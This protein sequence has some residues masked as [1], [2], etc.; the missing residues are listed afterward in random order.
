[1]LLIKNLG[2][3]KSSRKVAPS[4]RFW[5]LPLFICLILGGCR[6]NSPITDPPEV[7]ATRV[8]PPT[9][10]KTSRQTD[11]PAPIK[12]PIRDALPNSNSSSLPIPSLW[13]GLAKVRVAGQEVSVPIVLTFKTPKH[14][15]QN[16]FFFG[17][18]VGDRGDQAGA[19]NLISS[20][21]AVVAVGNGVLGLQFLTIKPTSKGFQAVLTKTEKELAL[22]MNT[23]SG[24]NVTA[25]KGDIMSDIQAGVSGSNDLYIFN[26]GAIINVEFHEG[27]LV[28]TIKGNGFSAV[29]GTSDI[30]YEAIF[31]VIR[32]Q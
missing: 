30:P 13:R 2:M 23:F 32:D 17:L 24:I 20:T 10:Q 25:Q 6:S 22:A 14:G 9:P 19:A 11:S 12:A 3:V 21:N 27:A 1:M 31:Q 8:S 4:G 26:E 5:K 28:G 29:W 7:V 18:T 16:P 15:E